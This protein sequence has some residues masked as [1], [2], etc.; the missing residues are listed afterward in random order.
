M[1][2]GCVLVSTNPTNDR[3]VLQKGVDYI[4]VVP[5]EQSLADALLWIKD[6]FEE[7]MQ[8]GI[9]GA[10]TVKDRFDAGKIVRSKLRHMFGD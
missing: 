2:T 4:E 3:L 8:I 1:S 6:N 10:A 9:N 5:E 7:A